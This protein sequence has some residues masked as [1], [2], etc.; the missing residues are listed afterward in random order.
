[1]AQERAAHGRPFFYLSNRCSA[2][3]RLLRLTAA[4]GWLLLPA[5]T[6]F[7]TWRWRLPDFATAAPS[8]ARLLPAATTVGAGRPRLA[9][10]LGVHLRPRRI[11]LLPRF[12][13]TAALIQV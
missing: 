8:C 10:A 5:A 11:H 1:M 6:A 9:A 2:F 7:G 12:A 4:P 3:A 13:A